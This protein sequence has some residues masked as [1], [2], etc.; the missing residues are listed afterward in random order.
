MRGTQGGKG[1]PGGPDRSLKRAKV[2][3]F[4][5]KYG[6]S[7]WKLNDVI[8]SSALRSVVFNKFREVKSF[9]IELRIAK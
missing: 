5:R 7:A 2:P 4:C 6:A 1:V 8:L 3:S 9:V